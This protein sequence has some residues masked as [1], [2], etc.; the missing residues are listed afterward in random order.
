MMRTTTSKSAT[1]VP[2]DRWCLTYSG[3]RVRIASSKHD[4]RDL[5]CIIKN[6]NSRKQSQRLWAQ[7]SDDVRRHVQSCVHG[8][9]VRSMTC[10]A[11]SSRSGT[12]VAMYGP[13]PIIVP[14]N[15]RMTSHSTYTSGPLAR[16]I[17]CSAVNVNVAWSKAVE[18][19]GLIDCSVYITASSTRQYGPG[20]L[21]H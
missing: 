6:L 10:S 3:K 1:R 5:S 20:A 14:A 17:N 8:I 4:E 11:H 9:H 2:G 7:P 13:A 15:R 19:G 21:A 12:F 18:I 16:L